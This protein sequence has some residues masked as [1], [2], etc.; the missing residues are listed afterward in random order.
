M[1]EKASFCPHC[2]RASFPG[3]VGDSGKTP[4]IIAKM[5]GGT[6]SWSELRSL[7][8][9]YGLLMGFLLIFGLT[10]HL[11]LGPNGDVCFSVFWDLLVVVFLIREW[12]GVSRLFRIRPPKA[13]ILLELALICVGVYYFLQGYFHFLN[14]LNWPMAEMSNSYVKAGW[15]LGA[16]LALNSVDPGIFEEI[17]FRGII[18]T[19]LARILSKREALVIQAALFSVLHLSPTIFLSHFVMGLVLGWARLRTGKIYYGMFLHMAWNAF[20]LLQ[21]M[22]K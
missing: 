18:Q 14:Y 7:I 10:A 8:V 19:K 13:K 1:G 6:S 21:E 12:K 16:I 17:A 11:H 9:F 22:T 4:P 20:V 5:R 2:G 3:S 15:S